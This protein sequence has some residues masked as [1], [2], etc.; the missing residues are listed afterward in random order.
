MKHNQT[1]D[2]D[3]LILCVFLMQI[4]VIWWAAI[5]YEF[6]PVAG[7]LYVIYLLYVLRERIKRDLAQSAGQPS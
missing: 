7:A 2:I 4:G 3:L 1:G 5:R 6:V